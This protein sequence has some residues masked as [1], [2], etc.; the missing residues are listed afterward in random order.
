MEPQNCVGTAAQVK[1]WLQRLPPAVAKYEHLLQ[2]AIDL[3]LDD[4]LEFTRKE[5]SE[6]VP[7]VMNNRTDSLFRMLDAFFDKVWENSL[8]LL[9]GFC[10]LMSCVLSWDGWMPP[11]LMVWCGHK[12][13][14][15]GEWVMIVMGC[16]LHLS[17]SCSTS[18]GRALRQSILGSWQTSWQ[19]T[20]TQCSFSLWCG[21]WAGESAP[22][23]VVSPSPGALSCGEAPFFGVSTC[24]LQPLL[25]MW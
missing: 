12:S 4:A 14:E 23:V 11:A 3:F 16:G 17:V 22:L 5:C 15:E 7:T 13:G 24:I 1:T 9:L 21:V 6:Y 8:H 10:P 20:S 19:T 2:E 25:Q 18:S